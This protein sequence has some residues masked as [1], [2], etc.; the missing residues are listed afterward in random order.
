MCLQYTRK[1]KGNPKATDNNIGN[2]V[3]KNRVLDDAPILKLTLSTTE[4]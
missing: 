2:A 1:T 4:T 3:A